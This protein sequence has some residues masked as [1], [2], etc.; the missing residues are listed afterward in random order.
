MDKRDR[1]QALYEAAEQLDKAIDN[2]KH[3]LRG[4]AY[5]GHANAY[6]IP[7]LISWLDSDNSFNMGIHQYINQLDRKEEDDFKD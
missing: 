7:H 1:I 5:E 6:I 3:A 4:T 2:I